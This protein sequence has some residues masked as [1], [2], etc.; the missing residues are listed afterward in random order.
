MT[1]QDL[2]PEFL[3]RLGEIKGKRAKIV[4]NHILA[5]GFITT[6]ELKDTYNYT[7]P[8][9][10]VRDVREQGIPIEQFQVKDAS[11]RNIAAYRFGNPSEV[12][13]TSLS[14]TVDN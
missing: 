1:Q 11:G 14:Y 2:P 10:A 12:R 8:P 5:H 9:R 6:E 13:K 3:A 4:V 7:H